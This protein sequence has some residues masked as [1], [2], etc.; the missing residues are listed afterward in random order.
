MGSSTL[1]ALCIFLL[2][3]LIKPEIEAKL[4]DDLLHHNAKLLKNIRSYEVIKPYIG[5]RLKRHASTRIP[6]GHLQE[7][8][9][10]INSRKRRFDL[11]VS[12][13]KGL[14]KPEFEEHYVSNDHSVK[15]VPHEHCYYHGVVKG[16]KNSDVSLSTCD[17]IEGVIRTADGTFFIEPL[18][19][20]DGQVLDD[21]IIFNADDVDEQPAT[22]GHGDHKISLQK[23]INHKKS[24]DLKNRVK[25]NVETETK[26]IELFIINDR[27]QYQEYQK[28]TGKRAKELVNHL[29]STFRHR[30]IRVALVG[31]ETWTD[32]NLIYVDVNITKTLN[33]FLEY[34]RKTHDH[35]HGKHFDNIQLISGLDFLGSTVG[36]APIQSICGPR[37][38][39][40]VQDYDKRAALTAS[41]MAHEL[42]HNFGMKHDESNCECPDPSS[43]CV[44]SASL[45]GAAT[46]FSSCSLKTLRET[47]NGGYGTCLFDEPI[48][49]YGDP[50][51]RNGVV[52]EG[53]ECD[54]GTQ[55]ECDHFKQHCCNTTTCTL[56]PGAACGHGECCD[57]CQFKRRGAL[58]RE[59]YNECDLPEF[60]TGDH[61]MCPE[62]THIHDG[63][64]CET[65]Q[66]GYCYGGVCRHLLL[67][68]QKLFGNDIKVGG[69]NCFHRNTEGGSF[70][71]CPSE[72]GKYIRCAEK[73]VKCGK[74]NCLSTRKDHRPIQG[75]QRY[76]HWISFKTG[77]YCIVP[78]STW[79]DGLDPTYADDGTPC[80]EGNMCLKGKCIPVSEAIPVSS[81]GKCT[82]NCS[83]NGICN[84]KGNCHCHSGFACPDCNSIGPNQGG[85]EDSGQGCQLSDKKDSSSSTRINVAAAVL[86]PLFL[87]LLIGI[88]ILCYFKRK[89]I[90]ERLRHYKFVRRTTSLSS[91]SQPAR[92]YQA[93]AG[94][95]A[96]LISEP[97]P[98]PQPAGQAAR[99]APTVPI[100]NNES[101]PQ[102]HKPPQRPL[103]QP[104]AAA[105]PLNVH[106]SV[107]LFPPSA[108][109]VSQEPA[110]KRPLP[111]TRPLI[112]SNLPRT[113]SAPPAAPNNRPRLPPSQPP[114][115]YK[116]VPDIPAAAEEK[117]TAPP[118]KGPSAPV[119]KPRNIAP[120]PGHQSVPLFNLPENEND[121]GFVKPS[122]VKATQAKPSPPRRPRTN[123]NQDDNRVDFRAAL[124][125]VPKPWEKT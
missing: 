52:E 63:L 53:E 58:C 122:A 72:P 84:N 117:T 41:T 37:S 38:A 29:D 36:Y 64:P 18:K 13:N 124:K 20:K 86:I 19:S 120:R 57:N 39:A 66:D 21:H 3:E 119:P 79:G 15:M 116:S 16:D 71:N 24:V 85:S 17:G 92:K 54:C 62:D 87:L 6:S 110:K 12:L 93:S 105:Q 74:I 11:A 75:Q 46:R 103:T 59:Q 118:K 67:Q 61:G 5:E 94:L 104:V 106:Q 114:P 76:H 1:Y 48:K 90:Q 9:I 123:E 100:K 73:D 125:P 22:C 78:A 35:L 23:K 47:L 40:V 98:S 56:I 45:S 7:T 44:M 26:Y 95:H 81:F 83:G 31:V 108:A 8:T 65:H 113:P 68:C 49:H 97:S 115:S 51:C 88:A 121:G 99:R 30:N 111:P 91:N 43:Q 102:V 109:P 89:A 42:G 32:R 77:E 69:D 4:T 34:K 14:F 82:N 10:V 107:A 2:I 80:S 60:C 50:V 33:N 101:Y 112:K 28:G 27:R 25:R 96:G 70:Y 55:E